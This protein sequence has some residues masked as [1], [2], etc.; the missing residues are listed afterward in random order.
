MIREKG[1]QEKESTMKRYRLL[2]RLFALL[3]MILGL[4][5]A[6]RAQG[7]VAAFRCQARVA[8]GDTDPASLRD[9][10]RQALLT[11]GVR[12]AVASLLAPEEA[13]RIEAALRKNVYA[14]PDRYVTTY[15]IFSEQAQADTLEMSGEITVSLDLLRSDLNHLGVQGI[16]SAAAP[17]PAPAPASISTSAPAAMAGGTVGTAQALAPSGSASPPATIPE[18]KEP[19]PAPGREV[20][21]VVAERWKDAWMLPQQDGPESSPFFLGVNQ[22]IGDYGW[23]LVTPRAGGVSQQADGG[24]VLEDA[25]AL[26]EAMAIPIVALGRM[27]G[28]QGA[29]NSILASTEFR[30]IEVAGNRDLGTIHQQWQALGVN[31]AEAA[32]QLANLVVPGIDQVLSHRQPAAPTAGHGGSTAKTAPIADSG[33]AAM[34]GPGAG[35]GPLPALPSGS[36]LLSAAAPATEVVAPAAGEQVIEIRGRQPYAVW[37]AFQSLLTGHSGALHVTTLELAPHGVR[38]HVTGADLNLFATFNGYRLN[39]QLVLRLDQVR[40]QE[41]TITFSTVPADQPPEAGRVEQP[42]P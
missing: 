30:L 17:S 14:R 39:D 22:E 27:S 29:D 7:D 35:S 9:R 28:Q 24:A 2:W 33:S 36:A 41:R 5:A 10:T 15:Q 37:E 11:D 26:A 8:V 19:A 3:V 31:G 23:T 6:A 20:L 13:S 18:V 16:R 25:L 42:Q 4:A 21:W 1:N 12:Q 38:A 40:Q 32:V 34:A